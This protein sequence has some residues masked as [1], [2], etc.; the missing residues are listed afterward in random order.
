L[1]K[2]HEEGMS[3]GMPRVTVCGAGA[4]GTAIAADLA[5]KGLDIRLYEPAEFEE[6]ISIFRERGGI[7]LTADSA[8]T[9][10][11]TGFV[12]L[13]GVT[14]DPAEAVRGANVLMITPP[15]LHHER[16]VRE[17]FPHL[18]RGQLVVFN[19]GYWGSLRFAQ[20]LR[21]VG[22]FDD[23][24]LC[25]TNIMPYL[26]KRMGGGRT[27]IFNAK[28]VMTLAAFPGERTAD[29]HAVLRQ[30]YNE[31]KAVSN[32]L[33]TN[34]SSGGNWC[35]HV[36]LTIPIMGYVFDRFRGCKFYTEATEQFSRLSAAFDRERA[37]LAE[38]LG[39]SPIE[40]ATEWARNAYGYE[41][42]DL[43]DA[44]RKSPHADRY[45][46]LA[47]LDRVLDE[48]IGYS[49]V[50]MT[51]IAR[52]LGLRMSITEG[53]INVT[54]AMLEKDYWAS[55]LSLGALGLEGMDA[56]GLCRFVDRGAA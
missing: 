15:A 27:R 50:P 5:H 1:K 25:E 11:K 45:S 46:P 42:T 32:V 55:G 34:I 17:L 4:A 31:Y 49:F 43:A 8:S 52:A 51:R 14:T 56:E 44:F 12:A 20:H 16:F 2:E 3:M 30:T 9:S 40:S 26:S 54:G 41:G 53:M 39:C 23:V 19:T 36:Q 38:R 10:G 29:A 37:P 28:R 13:E 33:W 47:A 22:R 24:T 48:D 7:E 21:N 6:G 35:I 18:E